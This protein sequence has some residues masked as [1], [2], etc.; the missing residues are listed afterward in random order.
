VAILQHLLPRIIYPKG[1]GLIKSIDEKLSVN[2]ANG[3]SG[4][5]I[6]FPFSASRNGFMPGMTLGYSSGSGNSEFGLGW[7]AEPAP[8]V[9]RTDKLNNYH[10]I[11]T[12][13]SLIFLFFQAPDLVPAFTKDVSGKFTIYKF[14]CTVN[15]PE[16]VDG[17]LSL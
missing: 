11:M 4:C 12:R 3:T 16:V 13:M 10:S 6:S 7:N 5:S 15:K 17:S 1:G 8:I 9:R 14:N 2:A